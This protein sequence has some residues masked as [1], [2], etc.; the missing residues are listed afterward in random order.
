MMSSYEG[1][2]SHLCRKLGEK[3]EP[4]YRLIDTHFV[5]LS[6]QEISE[7]KLEQNDLVDEYGKHKTVLH[8]FLVGV[9]T[10]ESQRELSSLELLHERYVKS[11][12]SFRDEL[13]KC[14]QKLSKHVLPVGASKHSDAGNSLEVC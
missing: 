4:I 7:I 8:N 11:T 3:W 13:T 14:K 6:L 10:E 2:L 1:R 5:P 12:T 9:K